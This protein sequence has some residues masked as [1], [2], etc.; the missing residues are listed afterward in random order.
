MFDWRDNN[1]SKLYE[2]E[3]EHWSSTHCCNISLSTFHAFSIIAYIFRWL[4]KKRCFV[5]FV[6]FISQIYIQI[7]INSMLTNIRFC[8]FS[9][10]S[11]FFRIIFLNASKTGD[12]GV[13]YM[14]SQKHQH[15]FF[16]LLRMNILV[17]LMCNKS[18]GRLSTSK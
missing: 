16:N 5:W 14:K 11:W 15:I 18:Y 10:L 3:R 4:F 17:G 9:Y 6:L 8:S 13:T 7:R 12:R 2:W 1:V